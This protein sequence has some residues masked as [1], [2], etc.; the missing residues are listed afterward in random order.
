MCR[1][2]REVTL[3]PALWARVKLTLPHD[4]DEARAEAF[5][6][7]LLARTG[8]VESMHVDIRTLAQVGRRRR[9][10]RARPHRFG[11]MAGWASQR[12]EGADR[13]AHQAAAPRPTQ[14]PATEAVVGVIQNVTAALMAVAATLR[15]LTFETAGCL[16]VG[17]WAAALTQVRASL[18][19]WLSWPGGRAGKDLATAQLR[20]PP[21]T[22]LRLLLS[23]CWRRRRRHPHL[24]RSSPLPA[25]SAATCTS[26]RAWASCGG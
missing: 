8:A 10:G 4:D 6:G 20:S 21:C 15:H 9:H 24:L 11:C 5:L 17:Q 18:W 26:S 23:R 13:R 3:S 2:W 1:A 16:V 12:S 22:T 14:A 25:S 19:Q 7:W